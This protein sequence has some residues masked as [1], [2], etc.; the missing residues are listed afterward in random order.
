MGD[1]RPIGSERLQGDEKLSRILEIPT[2]GRTP[3]NKKEYT[4]ADYSIQLADGN[5]YGI[6]KE[7][8]GY[9]V[10]KGINESEFDYLDPIKNRKYHKKQVQ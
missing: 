5:Y 9:I 1:L 7:K 8:L 10:K 2:Y 3:E 4:S 6:V